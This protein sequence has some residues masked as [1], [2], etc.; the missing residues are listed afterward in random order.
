VRRKPSLRE[1]A[2]EN[3]ILAVETGHQS[4]KQDVRQ[5]TANPKRK[6]PDVCC[7]D[8]ILSNRRANWRHDW[9]V[10]M[11]HKPKSLTKMVRCQPTKEQSYRQKWRCS[12]F[13][14]IPSLSASGGKCT[15]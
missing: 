12:M 7:Y 14:F 8:E 10:V 5:E 2:R 9:P 13:T 15:I 6:M 11:E 3:G 4:A 1:W